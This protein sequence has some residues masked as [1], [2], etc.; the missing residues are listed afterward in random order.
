MCK[1]VAKTQMG[2]GNQEQIFEIYGLC[3]GVSTDNSLGEGL[4]VGGGGKGVVYSKGKNNHLKVPMRI[5]RRG[6]GEQNK[7]KQNT[8]CLKRAS[9]GLLLKR[10]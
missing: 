4:V 10:G 1:S 7:I 8:S 5:K 6:L 2:L 3:H 9:E